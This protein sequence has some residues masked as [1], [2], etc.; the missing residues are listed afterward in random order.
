MR[1]YAVKEI[2]RISDIKQLLVGT[3]IQEVQA[4]ACKVS[5]HRHGTPRACKAVDRGHGAHST[6]PGRT[7]PAAIKSWPKA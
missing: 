1:I 3:I 5:T 2:I 6:R 7:H 4:S